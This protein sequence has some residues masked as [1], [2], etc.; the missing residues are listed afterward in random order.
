M[1][2]HYSISEPEQN[3]GMGYCACWS[4]FSGGFGDDRVEEDDDD[5]DLDDDDDDDVEWDE[6]DDDDYLDDDEDEEAAKA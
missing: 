5:D 1:M 3:N 6:W 4:P 2:N